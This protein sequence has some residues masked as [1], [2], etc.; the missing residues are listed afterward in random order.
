M[1][2]DILVFVSE[3]GAGKDFLLNQCVNKFGWTKV[4][5]HTTRPI[6]NSIGELDGKDY[7]FITE[8]M[9]H[10]LKEDGQF[11]ETTEYKTTDRILHY[12]FHKDSI[13][14]D[15][16]KCM[17]LNPDGVSQLINNGYGD[18]MMI[19]Y[20]NCP[21]QTRIKRYHNRLGDNPTEHQ[22]A[23]GFLRLLR[24]IYD[25]EKFDSVIIEGGYDQYNWYKDVPVEIVVNGDDDDIEWN[26]ETIH[27][28]ARNL[29]GE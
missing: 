12:G 16:I 29:Y 28:F 26:L 19:V 3:A 13:K 25:F 2:R 15:G 17:I 10:Q 22:L 5:S 24:D 23:E 11:I 21:T 8:G 18:R 1:S 7:L 27:D 20:V 4:I 14:G 9:F 6:R